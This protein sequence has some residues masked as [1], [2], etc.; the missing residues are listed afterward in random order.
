[1][2]FSATSAST[3]VP[4]PSLKLPLASS[5]S[6]IERQRRLGL[7]VAVE[8]RHLAGGAGQLHRL[9]VVADVDDDQ[10]GLGDQFQIAGLGFD[11]NAAVLGRVVFGGECGQGERGCDPG[12]EIETSSWFFLSGWGEGGHDQ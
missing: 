1:L 12:A 5:L 7:V 2:P 4:A 3:L 9:A 8:H 6:P 10:F 11:N